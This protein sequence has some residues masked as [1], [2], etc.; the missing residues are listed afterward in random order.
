VVATGTAPNYQWRRNGVPIAGATL[1]SYTTPATI[2][3]D[4]GSLFS[5]VA[6]NS[7]G[8]V[9]SSNAT[10]TV[11][12]V[13]VQPAIQTQP[14]DA[15]ASEGQA[16]TLTVTP[17]GSAPLNYQ[18]RRN[19]VP[20]AGATAAS[21]TTAPTVIGDDDVLFSVVVGNDHPTK[22]T[23]TD[24]KLDVVATWTGIREDGATGPSV[25]S[26]HAV[27]TD[28]DGNVIIAGKA[29]GEFPFDP[30]GLRSEAFVAKYSS[31]GVLLWAH[32]SPAT[33][34]LV[35]GD[36]ANGVGTDAAGNIYVVGLTAGTLPGQISAG[37]SDVTVI[38][39]DPAGTL[40]WARQFGSDRADWGQAAAVDAGGNVF[41]AGHTQGQLPLQ[42]PGVGRDFFIAK[43]DT[44]GNRLWIRQTP[45]S[46]GTGDDGNGVAVDAAGNAYMTGSDERPGRD[47]FVAK[48]DPDGTLV[49]ISH[50]RTPA[51]GDGYA[52]AV[53]GDGQTIYLTGRTYAD[54]A[55]PGFPK[56]NRFCCGQYDAFVARMDGNGV[57]QWA[58]NLQPEIVNGAYFDARGLSIS[59]DTSG[60][61]AFITGW[62]T[63][64]MP[65]QAS[66]GAEDIFIARYESNGNRTWVKQLGADIPATGARNDHGRAI[67]IVSV[68]SA[69][70]AH[71]RRGRYSLPGSG[72][73]RAEGSAVAFSA[74]TT[75][76]SNTGATFQ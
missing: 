13:V 64:V 43:F 63:G 28:R 75:R 54:F 68:Q 65:G 35:N 14:L 49:W 60:S 21:Y 19:G 12:P 45:S 58:R 23:S 51:P 37:H 39:Y 76:L 32:K 7:A 52:V 50:I 46:G 30:A 33:G 74:S 15:S 61:V 25:D 41:I 11:G 59:T 29:D 38:K 72:M 31:A 6:S 70:L 5:V 26:A 71:R 42:A 4:S 48:Y 66:N 16:A 20:I 24:A 18:W 27:A 57:L 1:A 22:A 9:T 55:L 73:T 56:Q 40:L 44:N 10:L 3:A 47:P 8:S 62:T 36:E 17:T 34:N 67:T 69:H 53:A 2:E